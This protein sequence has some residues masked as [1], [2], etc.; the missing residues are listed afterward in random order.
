MLYGKFS[1][2][3]ERE[4]TVVLTNRLDLILLKLRLRGGWNSLAEL[5]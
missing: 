5:S 4:E 1:G 3:I 2:H